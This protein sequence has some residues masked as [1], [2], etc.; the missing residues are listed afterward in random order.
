MA[1]TV[2]AADRGEALTVERQAEL[3]EKQ[4]YTLQHYAERYF[5]DVETN[6]VMTDCFFKVIEALRR[7]GA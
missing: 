7:I 2:L 6:C 5:E 4:P 1:D 3:H